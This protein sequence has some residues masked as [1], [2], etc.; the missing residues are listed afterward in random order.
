MRPMSP[1]PDLAALLDD[2][3]ELRLTLAADLS[4]AAG[5]AEAG[6]DD[7][8]ADI[9]VGDQRELGAFSRRSRDRLLALDGRT[10]VHTGLGATGQP[11]SVPAAHTSRWRRRAL[12]ALPTVPLVGA[13]AISAAAAMGYFPAST[14][15]HSASEPRIASDAPA[16]VATT[17]NEL[18][19]VLANDPSESQVVAAATAL[20]QQLEQLIDTAPDNPARVDEVA[21]VLQ[22]EQ[23]LLMR[24][25]PPGSARVLAASRQL[26]KRLLSAA[27]SAAPG[28]HPTPA[29]HHASPK[30]TPTTT[31]PA[32]QSTTAASSSPAPTRSP[33]PTHSPT[34]RSTSWPTP[35][36]SSSAS[37]GHLPTLTH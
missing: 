17:F 34:P 16:P 1:P 6:A 4:A 9:V 33:S 10:D 20:H 28:A 30:P 27:E 2:V 18:A 12:V 3:R 13:V 21:K 15:S 32:G 25:Q 11:E 8:V 14:P 23:A 7:L 19:T 5:A 37:P 31:A 35:T 22:L 29:A 26:A 36:S 24:A